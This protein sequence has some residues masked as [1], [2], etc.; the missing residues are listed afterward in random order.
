MDL[1]S[2][3]V[4]CLHE[5]MCLKCCVISLNSQKPAILISVV[6]VDLPTINAVDKSTKI[7][8]E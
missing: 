2:Q 7:F 6:C 3:V 1:S 4:D 5:V 8:S